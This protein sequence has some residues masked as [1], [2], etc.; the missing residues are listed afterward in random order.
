MAKKDDGLRKIEILRNTVCGGEAV[1][2]G[3]VVSAPRRDA[4]ALVALKKARY[5]EA[6]EGRA[7]KGGLT[8]KNAGG[9]IPGRE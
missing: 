9:L 1:E 7:A 4:E 3:D 6:K 5:T 2:A 8:T